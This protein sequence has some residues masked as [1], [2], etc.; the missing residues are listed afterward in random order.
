MCV[1]GPDQSRGLMNAS[2]EKQLQ[3]VTL[4]Y[5]LLIN[6]ADSVFQVQLPPH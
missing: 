6:A 4:L 3:A 5:A 1:V 2:Q